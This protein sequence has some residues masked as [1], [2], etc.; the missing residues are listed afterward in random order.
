MRPCFKTN[1]KTKVF[2]LKTTSVPRGS[3]LAS[4]EFTWPLLGR[5]ATVQFLKFPPLSNVLNKKL[6]ILYLHESCFVFVFCFSIQGFL[7]SPAC[8]GTDSVD[9]AGLELNFHLPWPLPRSSPVLVFK[10]CITTALLKSFHC[11]RT[12][13]QIWFR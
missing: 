11:N 10:V 5:W 3:S 1:L 8:P 12:Y 7:C 6:F 13:N 9:Q 2:T 4:N